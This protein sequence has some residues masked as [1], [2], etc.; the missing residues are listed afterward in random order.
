MTARGYRRAEYEAQRRHGVLGVFNFAPSRVPKIITDLKA[1]KA[2]TG[3]AKLLFDGDSNYW[4]EG[5][6]D[7][8]GNNRVNAKERCW[9]TIFAK[10]LTT[11]GIPA[12]YENLYASGAK[13]TITAVTDFLNSYKTGFTY[14]GTGWVFS[15]S[16]TLGGCLWTNTTDLTSTL[17][18]TP[19]I[20]CDTIELQYPII[21]TAGS[22]TY[23]I[24][25]GAPVTLVQ[26]G[27]NGVHRELI[28]LGSVGPHTIVINRLSGNAFFGGYRAWNSTVKQADCINL[29]YGSANTTDF[30]LNTNAWSCM[31][32]CV[33]MANG[34]SGIFIGSTINDG[35]ANMA[36]ATY[37][38]NINALDAAFAATGADVVYTT[39]IP[40]NI[41]SVTQA[42]QDRI[43]ADLKA[44]AVANNRVLFAFFDKYGDW[45]AMNTK[46]F[47]YNQNHA[48]TAG[49]ADIGNWIG[50]TVAAWAA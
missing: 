50:D 9:P 40:S 13:S 7:S 36:D 23:T 14:T 29:G 37:I 2:G 38:A 33:D 4:G 26:T 41:A 28:A 32:A 3:R 11:L 19:Q 47:I 45:N 15:G 44:R 25:G 21:T 46:G 39:G 1:V 8:G 34:A 35:I 18:I 48:N 31:P 27:T 5:G 30:S 17:S 24:D 16:T 42:I 20:N 22:I 12:N 49:Y 10:R 43:L 6:G